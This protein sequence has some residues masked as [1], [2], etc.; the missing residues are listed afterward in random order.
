MCVP[1]HVHGELGW[2]GPGQGPA[3][4]TQPMLGVVA[5]EY[6]PACWMLVCYHAPIWLL[7]LLQPTTLA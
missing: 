5:D 1:L 2:L 4:H 6:N 7:L 3:G